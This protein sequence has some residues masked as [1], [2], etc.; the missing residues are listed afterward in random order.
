M[1]KTIFLIL[2]AFCSLS[3]QKV[4]DQFSIAVAAYNNQ[5]YSKALQLFKNVIRDGNLD[6][7]NL[8]VADFYSADCLLNLDQLDGAAA[9]LESFIEKYRFSNFRDA[10]LYK[11]GTIYFTKGEFRKARE[12]LLN[13]VS[14]FPETQ[15]LGS[16]YYW[17][18]ETF[19]SENKYVEA[20]ENFRE[21]L[22]QKRTNKYVLNNIY[23]LAQLYEK[24]ND[25]RSAVTFY[26]EL[27]AYYK[28]T[29]LGPKAQMRIGVC[30]FNLKDYDNAILELSDPLIKKL[31]PEELIQAKFFL[32][33]SFIRL[34]DY[35]GASQIYNELLTQ[36]SDQS[37]REKINYSLAWINFQQNDYDGAFKIFDDLSKN[38]NDSL[39]ILSFFWSGEC[40]RYAGD[41]KNANE[42]YQQFISKYPAH[43]LA[44]KAQLGMGSVYFNQSN[45][46]DAEK[47]LLNATLSNDVGT[48][49][50][51]YTLLGET[52]LN[53]KNFD[54]AKKYFAE[55]IKLTAAQPELNHRAKL[56]LAVAEFYL[57]DY[58]DAAAN[59]EDLKSRAKE[60]ETDKVN[61]YLAESYFAQG[62]Y[63]LAVK[64]YNIVSS[65]SEDLKRQ[66]VLGKGY[67][68]FNLKDY[69]NAI[70]YFSEYV[71][72][73]GN[74]S[75]IDE[76]RLRLADSYFGVKKFDKASGLYREL[77]SK[78]K[79]F[80]NNDIAYYQFGQ[81]LFKAGKSSEAV[82][83]FEELQK[84][85]PHSKYLDQSQYI[86]G[87]INFQQNKFNEAISNYKTVLERYPKS[88]LRPIVYY[89]IGDAY[90]NRGQ[91]DSSIV[92]YS[93]VIEEFPNTQYIFDAVNGI[94]YA[95]VA[96]E[97]PDNAINFIDQFIASN[98]SSKFSDQIY[99]KKGDLFYSIQKYADAIRSYKEFITRYSY[100]ALIP[101]AYFW[102]GKSAANMNN[103]AEAINNFSSARQRSLKT[104]I[105]ISSTIE[106]SK[107]YT[108]KKQ[109]AN[110]VNVLKEA[111][112]A[113]PTSNRV[114]ELLFLQGLNQS[115]D[116][117]P[118]E[119]VSTFDQIVQ[120]YEGSVFVAKA[121]VELGIIELQKNNY[122]TAQ[123][124]FVEVGESKT[125]DIGAEAQYYYGVS[126][127][128][129]N[130]IQDAITAL[131]RV[132]SVF[133]AYDE[134]Y[135]K[136]LLKLGDCYVKLNDKK[137]ARDMYR[138]VIS[139]HDTGELAQEAKKKM[140]QL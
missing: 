124:Y 89:S 106:L 18:G 101:N 79:S 12:K 95:Y 60:F 13:L 48:R 26:D 80:L 132:R 98:P 55:A 25:F 93:K 14:I 137:Q 73:Y 28:D 127:F 129:Q 118:T 58:N 37:S 112:E 115:K 122:E 20:E 78:E 19:S 81:S 57:N 39:K 126:L 67:S 100:S 43:R 66:T 22:S 32:A 47:S 34:K 6:E 10:A 88:T 71:S 27:L 33:N 104:D 120:Y 35:K 63:T 8:A 16:A 138:A 31:N 46:S 136:S 38:G 116:N 117:K 44:A 49:G 36:V 51:A 128:N 139:R 107:I 21:G 5:D 64:Q 65:S 131:V 75:G 85:F 109:F 108:D 77:F 113:S 87:W 135:T 15:Y 121:K 68:Y 90:F 86:V 29:P 94:Q 96:K 69:A 123:K 84:K 92:F 2:I 62:K 102:I 30:Y 59:L 114:P 24:T 82:K 41:V 1:K 61:F 97:Q 54:D 50:K 103:E 52:R 42:I 110:A 45:S 23:S 74:D 9:E 4:L 134:W 53:K 3:A 40:K 133:A 119:A 7:Q 11:L 111:I 99:F 130:K 70:F 83:A 76:I 140:K 56:G 125:D 72:K 17:I 105:G 91:Y